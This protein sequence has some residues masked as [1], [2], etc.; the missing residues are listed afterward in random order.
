MLDNNTSVLLGRAMLSVVLLFYVRTF[1]LPLR[2]CGHKRSQD[3][4]GRV[5]TQLFQLWVVIHSLNSVQVVFLS[6]LSVKV[7][8]FVQHC[9]QVA[10]CRQNKVKFEITTLYNTWTFWSH[11]EWPW[12]VSDVLDTLRSLCLY[13]E[14]KGIV[15]WWQPFLRPKYLMHFCQVPL[16]PASGFHVVET[17]EGLEWEHLRT[18]CCHCAIIVPL[19][20]WGVTSEQVNNSSWTT[21]W[22]VPG[23]DN[24]RRWV[25]TSEDTNGLTRT[26]Q[27]TAMQKCSAS[28]L[29]FNP[30]IA[31]QNETP[32][33]TR[34][35]CLCIRNLLL[36]RPHSTCAKLPQFVGC[37]QLLVFYLFA[38]LH[39]FSLAS[40]FLSILCFLV[41]SIILWALWHL[42]LCCLCC[43]HEGLA[44][45]GL[46]GL[47]FHSCKML[48]DASTEVFASTLWKEQKKIH[49]FSTF[50][51]RTLTSERRRSVSRLSDHR[52]RQARVHCRWSGSQFF[53]FFFFF[54]SLILGI[55]SDWSEAIRGIMSTSQLWVLDL[56]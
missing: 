46:V 7:P 1:T 48:Q 13:L 53:F 8:T 23:A 2:A 47:W 9:D 19:P 34:T 11:L 16:K 4:C 54:F 50:S 37:Y 43:S 42:S 40:W 3:D 28:F 55:G 6:P 15:D 24:E 33:W 20:T 49:I 38:S 25:S 35:Y 56:R 51:Q 41:P 12:D 22:K 36:S 32:T 27:R 45:H 44:S 52:H 14:A 29:W 10:R 26:R 39:L 18:P 30:T 21:T 17:W 5:T 31:I